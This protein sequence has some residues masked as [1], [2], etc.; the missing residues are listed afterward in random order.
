LRR[1]LDEV[2]RQKLDC[3]DVKTHYEENHWKLKLN[4]PNTGQ[5]LNKL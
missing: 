1:K 5:S 2:I 3:I 4:N